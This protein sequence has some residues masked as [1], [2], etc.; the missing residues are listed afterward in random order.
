MESAPL[1]KF[2]SYGKYI[3]EKTREV[4]QSTDLND[5]EFLA[6]DRVRQTIQSELEKNI[7]KLRDFD[8]YIKQ[9][10][11]PASSGL[12]PTKDENALYK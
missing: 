6:S 2:S 8:K 9:D 10:S 4:L 12:S 5:R 3:H 7:S 1:N 11:T